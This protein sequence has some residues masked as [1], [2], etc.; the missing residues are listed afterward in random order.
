MLREV[1]PLFILSEKELK[2]LE[3]RF[4]TIEE[5]LLMY[6]I[7]YSEIGKESATSRNRIKSNLK[8]ITPLKNDSNK[9]TY[10]ENKPPLPSPSP[11][12]N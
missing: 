2:R 3:A 9:P 5:E 12:I 1:V 8:I 4:S 10:I 11:A 7:I 6:D